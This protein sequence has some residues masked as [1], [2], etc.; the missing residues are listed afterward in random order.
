[1]ANMIALGGG[2]EGLPILL[3]IQEMG[4]TLIVV[5]G[6]TLSPGMQIA[7][8][9]VYASCYHADQ[10]L[11]ALGYAYHRTGLKPEACLCC[12]VDAP[13]V[14]AAVASAYGLP[15]L[16]P[17]A[18][19]LSVDKFSQKNALRLSGL[20]VPDY[21]QV[22]D[23]PGG[24]YYSVSKYI[25]YPTVVKPMDSRGA[26]GVSLLQPGDDAVPAM[27]AAQDASPTGRVL[28]ER[29]LPGPQLSTESIVVA[30]RVLFTAVAL[31]NYD[32]LAEFAPHIV[33]DGC[34]APVTWDSH[35]GIGNDVLR[36]P[37]AIDELITNACKALGWFQTGGG[38]VKGDLIIHTLEEGIDQLVILELAARLSGGFLSTHTIPLAYGVP[39][40][41]YAIRL[42]LGETIETHRDG[43]IYPPRQVATCQRYLF[44]APA[45]IGRHVVSV[46]QLYTYHN[47]PFIDRVGLAWEES[48]SKARFGPALDGIR[49][50]TYAVRPGDVL[51]PVI[52]HAERMGQAIAT[53][54]T[55]DEARERAQAAVAAMRGAIVLE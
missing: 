27:Q 22:M 53:G 8:V 12:A 21:R 14:S 20:P 10:V 34:D 52:S 37:A 30:G 15:G 54:A 43:F 16:S 18:A 6:N 9:P 24:P 48:N 33:E 44:P 7:D 11:P 36:L 28:M 29:Y 51:R 41:D 17:E 50:A 35:I 25:N 4:H 26:R 39:F 42:A 2:I 45:D 23:L 1:M 40:V 38:T 46:P 32:R 19:A 55:P 49:H 31:R 3:R 5:D 47:P 13:N